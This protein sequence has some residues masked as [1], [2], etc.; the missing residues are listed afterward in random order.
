VDDVPGAG[1]GPG[2][3]PEAVVVRLELFLRPTTIVT[4][5]RDGMGWQTKGRPRGDDGAM[6]LPWNLVG[7]ITSERAETTIYGLDGSV[8]GRLSGIL[9][10]WSFA[11]WLARVV[12]TYLPEIF[13]IDEDAGFGTEVCLRREV[14]ESRGRGELTSGA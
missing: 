12:A 7:G 10:D 14:K 5:T 13:V 1:S 3:M 8:I 11:A 9:Q 6:W 2:P 4:L